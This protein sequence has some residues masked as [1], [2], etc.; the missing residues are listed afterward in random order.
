MLK[1]N[2]ITFWITLFFFIMALPAY[3]GILDGKTFVGKNGEIGKKSSEDDEIKFENGKFFSVGCGKYGFGDAEYTTKADGDRVFFT[4]DIYSNKY[5]RITYSGF[6]KGD[7]LNGTFIWFD[8][9]KYDKP[10]QVK[11]WKGSVKK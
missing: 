4:A 1:K 2:A 3:S 11:W 6:V 10:E 5:G 8:K 7:D 9:G